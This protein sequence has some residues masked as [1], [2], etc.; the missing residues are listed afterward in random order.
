MLIETV[1]QFIYECWYGIPSRGG[2]G[3]IIFINTFK[4]KQNLIKGQIE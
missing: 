4:D 1:T 3:E 2:N